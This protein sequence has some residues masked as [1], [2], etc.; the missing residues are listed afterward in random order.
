MA[1]IFRCLNSQVNGIHLMDLVVFK[2]LKSG[3]IAG[4]R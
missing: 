2:M 4:A 3:G 1:M